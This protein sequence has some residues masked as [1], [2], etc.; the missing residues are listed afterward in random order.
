MGLRRRSVPHRRRRRGEVR[1]DGTRGEGSGKAVAHDP[2]L[3]QRRRVPRVPRRGGGSARGGG[4]GWRGFRVFHVGDAS[5]RDPRRT[6]PQPHAVRAADDSGEPHHHRQ[7]ADARRGVRTR[8]GRRIRRSRRARVRRAPRLRL[9]TVESVVQ[10]LRGRRLSRA[11]RFHAR[12]LQHRPR[13]VPSDGEHA[14]RV[15]GLARR[16]VPPRR[17]RRCAR[18]R[19]RRPGADLGDSPHG[20]ALCGR[21]PPRPGAAVRARTRHGASVAVPRRGDEGPPEAGRV[22][23]D[24]QPRLRR[25]ASLLRRLVRAARGCR[26]DRSA[27]RRRRVRGRCAARR[28]CVRR[29]DACRF[30][31]RPRRGACAGQARVRRL[32][33]DMVQELHGDGGHYACGRAR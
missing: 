4:E 5:S 17:P 13:E 14:G 18:G 23:E 7:V 12:V 26:M 32:L 9:D 15:N 29:D 16:A 22:D 33:G 11:R 8:H 30:R 27:R 6:R 19:V 10:R 2:R 20:A 25:R 24:G 3:A 28:G 21:Q 1:R 31:I